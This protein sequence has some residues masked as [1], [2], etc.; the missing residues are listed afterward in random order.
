M[1]PYYTR[2]MLQNGLKTPKN[3]QS[4]GK[5]NTFFSL[6]TTTVI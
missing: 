1:V 3:I 2:N 6:V 4:K 5:P